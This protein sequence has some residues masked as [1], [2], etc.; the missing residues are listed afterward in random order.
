VLEPLLELVPP[1]DEIVLEPPLESAL[2][3]LAPELP[4]DDLPPP[5]LVEADPVEPDPFEL[6]LLVPEPLPLESE[7]LVPSVPV[8]PPSVPPQPRATVRPTERNKNRPSRFIGPLR[9][10]LGN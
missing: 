1:V 8:S 2:E 10:P 9:L 7:L 6:E 5:E 4:D 3:P